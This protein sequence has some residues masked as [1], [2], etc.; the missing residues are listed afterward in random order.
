MG[1]KR[2]AYRILVGK[3]DG[4]IPLEN[5]RRSSVDNIK[6]NLREIV[7]AG[8]DWIDMTQ[9]KEPMEGSFEHGNEPSGSIKCWEELE[10]L[11]S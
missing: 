8:M 1:E 4:K 9:D 10:W 6:M 11:H 7:W 5:P 3:P 2:N